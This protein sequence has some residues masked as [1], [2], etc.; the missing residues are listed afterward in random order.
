[1]GNNSY[2]TSRVSRRR[3]L[4]AGATS[5]AAALLVAC[6]S[7]SGSSSKQTATSKIAP[8]VDDTPNLKRGG[9]LKSRSTLEHPTLDPL[10]GGG[11]VNLL[12]LTYS[13]L[14]RVSDGYKE[15]TKGD[16]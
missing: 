2:W 10:A 13:N 3:A 1:M 4:A 8:T 15:R 6:G 12:A 16:I 5:A 7:S 14:F 9:Q 11:H